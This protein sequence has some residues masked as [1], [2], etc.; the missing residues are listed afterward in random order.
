[1]DARTQAN[2]ASAM[3]TNFEV[4]VGTTSKPPVFSGN[5]SND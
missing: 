1:M 4:V 3:M 2:A 5:H